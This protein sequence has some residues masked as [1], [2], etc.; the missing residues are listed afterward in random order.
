MS[1]GVVGAREG[2]GVGEGVVARPGAVTV[3]CAGP[4]GGGVGESTGNAGV[5]RDMVARRPR[6]RR[7]MKVRAMRS[8]VWRRCRSAKSR[9]IRGW[10]GRRPRAR[11]WRRRRASD[12]G[13]GRRNAEETWGA[14]GFGRKAVLGAVLAA[15]AGAAAAG[16]VAGA[17]AWAAGARAAAERAAEEGT[18]VAGAVKEAEG[19]GVGKGNGNLACGVAASFAA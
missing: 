4:R 17:G 12:D 5:R 3:R 6:R 9:R 1:G 10:V 18:A 14:A 19:A 11:S 8:E 13:D 2:G 16:A 15:G 7:E